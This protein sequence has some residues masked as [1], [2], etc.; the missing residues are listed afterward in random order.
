MTKE[1]VCSPSST[2]TGLRPFNG[3]PLPTTCEY[4]NFKNYNFTFL[5]ERAVWRKSSPSVDWGWMGVDVP[6]NPLTRSPKLG[7]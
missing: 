1:T 5:L 4:L 6:K 7:T 3:T 2:S